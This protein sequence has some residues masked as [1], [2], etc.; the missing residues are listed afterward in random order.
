[1]WV[2]NDLFYAKVSFLDNLVKKLE[3][4]G[5]LRKNI[6]FSLPVPKIKFDPLPQ[7]IND[8]VFIFQVLH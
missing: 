3:V 8:L 6:W 4:A 5:V 1:M 7:A 2:G